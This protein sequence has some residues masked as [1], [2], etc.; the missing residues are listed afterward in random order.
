MLVLILAAAAVPHNLP[1][2]L[3]APYEQRLT[4]CLIT[5]WALWGVSLLVLGV[6][7]RI[8]TPRTIDE[9]TTVSEVF[10]W[11]NLP[12]HWREVLALLFL[13][14]FYAL[15]IL[16]IAFISAYGGPGY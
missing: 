7:Y 10:H 11:K 1:P 3:K 5:L 14:A 12:H 9:S 8:G 4:N 16:T 15:F 13:V 2:E 6:A